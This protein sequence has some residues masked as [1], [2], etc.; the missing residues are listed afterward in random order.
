[1]WL[2][3]ALVSLADISISV[4]DV[5]FKAVA[6]QVRQKSYIHFRCQFRAAHVDALFSP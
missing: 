5:G 4:P 2:P 3:I 1:L 6:I